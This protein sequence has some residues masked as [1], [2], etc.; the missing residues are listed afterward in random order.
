MD[1]L[2]FMS[3]FAKACS[4]ALM[5]M[6]DVNAQIDENEIIYHDYVDISIAISTPNGLVVPP[7]HNVDL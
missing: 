2:G 6:P 4:K 3:L 7:I 5:E 1:K